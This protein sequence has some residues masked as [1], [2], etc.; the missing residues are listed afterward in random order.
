MT[1]DEAFPKEIQLDA[2]HACRKTGAPVCVVLAQWAEESNY[3]QAMPKDSNNPFGMKSSPGSIYP[4]VASYTKEWEHG[5]Y[6]TVTAY[7]IKF[8][9]IQAAFEAH[10]HYLMRPDAW[11]EYQRAA[12]V[13]K[14]S[15]D[16]HT[17]IQLIAPRYATDPQYAR[18]LIAIVMQYSLFELNLPEGS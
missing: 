5:R 3:G 10:G 18:N 7:F 14:Q 16:W 1:R 8:P 17:F 6:V 11:P 12:A 15:G 9:S 2:Q 4:R 13:W